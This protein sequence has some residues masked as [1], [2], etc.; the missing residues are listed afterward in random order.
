MPNRIIKES[1]CVSE[2]IDSLNWF[3]EVLFYRLIVNCDDFGRFDGR[4]PVVKNRLF[5]L[6]DNVTAKAVEGGINKLASIGLV[7]MYECDGKPY[8]YLPTWNDHQSVRA[9]RSKYPA[10]DDSVNAHEIIC[11][12][13]QANVPVI[14]SESNSISE[15]ESNAKDARKAR[16]EAFEKFW[17]AYPRKEGKQ[18]AKAAF[19]KVNVP[20]DV[21][22]NAIE[23]QKESAQWN[24]D[25]GQF[26]PHPTTWLNGKRWEDEVTAS[27][28]GR[29]GEAEKAA[30]QRILDEDELMAIQRMLADN[31]L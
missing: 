16:E 15:S 31:S 24:K 21:L 27:G 20:L 23:Q 13:V 8:L 12:Q 3:E 28:N 29:L 14:Q 19:E 6:K 11:K 7:R 18:K 10:P 26:I 17:S 2:S 22:L 5:P 25:N 1:I 9:K 30:I 4:V